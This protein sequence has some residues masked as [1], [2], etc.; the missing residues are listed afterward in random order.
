MGH[1]P[2]QAPK[3]KVAPSLR[4]ITPL[5]GS[6]I[7]IVSFSSLALLVKMRVDEEHWAKVLNRPV[8]EVPE[9]FAC[10]ADS[11]RPSFVPMPFMFEMALWLSTILLAFGFV[12]FFISRRTN[13]GSA[14]PFVL[15]NKKRKQDGP[16]QR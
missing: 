1:N 4:S 7:T 2:Y 6:A 12:L 5:V 15:R 14:L 8:K 11:F 3:A 13:G 10:F 9:P 16:R